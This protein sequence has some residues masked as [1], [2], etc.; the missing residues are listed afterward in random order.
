MGNLNLSNVHV[1]VA[2]TGISVAFGKGT[3]MADELAPRVMVDN[4]SDQYRVFDVLR[5]ALRIGQSGR[6]P[7]ARGNYVEGKY[8]LQDYRC[9]DH[10]YNTRVP[11]EMRSNS[12]DQI[13]LQADQIEIARE[14][15]LVEKDVLLKAILDGSGASSAT[16]SPL[17]DA[18]GDAVKDILAG[19]QS[20]EDATGTDRVILGL[21][22]K[23]AR[24]LWTNNVVMERIKYGGTPNV[25]A[26]VMIEAFR[27]VFGVEEVT[28]AGA[29][30]NTALPD[31]AAV[32][33]DVWGNDV[34]LLAKPDRPGL[35]KLAAVYTIT[36]NPFTDGRAVQ[37]QFVRSWREEAHISDDFGVHDFYTQELVS[38]DGIYLLQNVIS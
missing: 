9:I 19:V 24:K 10:T 36:W 28:I 25:P 30:Q 7:G 32:L 6:A 12:D 22:K 8:T 11:D 5:E 21:S 27:V 23:V 37:G 3:F 35:K 15:I 2:L 13:D 26:R 18:D 29:Y 38:A 33:A 20:I 31:A 14:K 17:W 4:Q 1:D 34:Y 16:P